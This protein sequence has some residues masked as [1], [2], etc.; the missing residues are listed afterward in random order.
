M[1]NLKQYQNLSDV[2]LFIR[3]MFKINQPCIMLFERT[4][5]SFKPLIIIVVVGIMYICKAILKTPSVFLTKIIF[6]MIMFKISRYIID[7]SA[8]LLN[9]V[10]EV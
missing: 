3:A 10:G 9:L 6:N 4:E 2:T 5:I 1:G 7:S 8:I